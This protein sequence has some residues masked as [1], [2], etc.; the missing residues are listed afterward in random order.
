M[1]NILLLLCL[2]CSSAALAQTH[3]DSPTDAASSVKEE[4]EKGEDYI[5]HRTIVNV[6]GEVTTFERKEWDW[7][8]VFVLRDGIVYP[9]IEGEEIPI[10]TWEREKNEMIR[11]AAQ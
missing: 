6:N 1:K 9:H 7:G 5:L 10:V 11:R 4:E 3:N 2:F 8:G